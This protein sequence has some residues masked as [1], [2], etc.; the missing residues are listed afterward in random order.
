ML[1]TAPRKIY[2]DVTRLLSGNQCLSRI[3][4]AVS[5]PLNTQRHI[6]FRRKMTI[7]CPRIEVAELCLSWKCPPAKTGNHPF[8]FLSSILSMPSFRLQQ[9]DEAKGEAV[10]LALFHWSCR[11]IV[12]HIPFSNC[13]QRVMRCLRH[14]QLQYVFIG[15]R[16]KTCVITCVC[17]CVVAD[18]RV[19]KCVFWS[20][21]A[22]NWGLESDDS[23]LILE[24]VTWRADVTCPDTHSELRPHVTSPWC[25]FEREVPETN[26]HLGV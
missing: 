18:V 25:G 16:S 12:L 14:S 10:A 5:I 7:F 6:F 11:H 26:C 13:P 23:P 8:C 22:Q 17:V 4:C 2:L 19:D 15:R 9:R 24:E 3:N 20:R 1:N 21:A